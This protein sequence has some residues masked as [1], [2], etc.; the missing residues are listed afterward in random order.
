PFCEPAWDSFLCWPPAAAGETLFRPCPL[1]D[2]MGIIIGETTQPE[3]Y[4]VRSCDDN[5]IWTGNITNYTLCV[6]N[7]E[8]L[9]SSSWTPTIVALIVVIGSALSIIT[10]SLSLF[11]F[12][13]F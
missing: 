4:A 1:L 9:Y 12:F 3:L 10:L 5:G 6:P 2:S 7:I 11:I 8:E 13:Y